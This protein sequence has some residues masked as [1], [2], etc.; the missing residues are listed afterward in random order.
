MRNG[1]IIT[2]MGYR[3]DLFHK[4]WYVDDRLHRENGPAVIQY[5][6]T[7]EWWLNGVRHREDGPALE[8][9]NGIKEWWINGKKINCTSQEEF[10][11]L[12]KLKVFW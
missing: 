4:A 1:L 3:G 10:K 9:A 2:T 5:N 7:E 11:R 8:S 6:G 12:I